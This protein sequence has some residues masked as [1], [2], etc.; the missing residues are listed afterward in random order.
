VNF[1]GMGTLEIIIVLLVAFIFLGPERMVDAARMLGKMTREVR[2]M[3]A[4]VRSEM[5]DLVKEGE[6]SG[7][8]ARRPLVHRE[9]GPDPQAASAASVN[10]SSLEQSPDGSSQDDGPVTFR[11]S[12]SL[13]DGNQSPQQPKKED[14]S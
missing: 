1:L 6:D 11:R 3:T 13:T 14:P 9:G 4:D 12:A 2:R 10:S 7:S 8:T 5:R